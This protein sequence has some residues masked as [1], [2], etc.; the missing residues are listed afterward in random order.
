[1]IR[2]AIVWDGVLTTG[3]IDIHPADGIRHQRWRWTGLKSRP[4]KRLNRSGLVGV[5]GHTRVSNRPSAI[6]KGLGQVSAELALRDVVLLGEQSRGPACGPVAFEPAEGLTTLPCW[7]SASS[8]RYTDRARARRR[9]PRRTRP[10]PQSMVLR[11]R[12]DRRWI[13]VTYAYPSDSYSVGNGCTSAASITDGDTDSGAGLGHA[14]RGVRRR[15]GSR[16]ARAARCQID[17]LEL[18]LRRSTHR[19]PSGGSR[20]CC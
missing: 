20:C 10:L 19:L 17:G 9:P 12:P 3:G 4:N 15:H 1:V 5:S 7:S 14:K 6:H 11:R 16:Q 18:L 8:S 2:D 13:E